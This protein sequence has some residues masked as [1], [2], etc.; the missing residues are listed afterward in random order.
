LLIVQPGRQAITDFVVFQILATGG[1]EHACA[2]AE[3]SIYCWGTGHFGQLG[4][5]LSYATVP[6]RVD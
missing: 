4:G 5:R 3:G 6:Q 1:A 2:L